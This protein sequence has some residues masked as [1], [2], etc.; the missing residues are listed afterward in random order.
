MSEPRS[1]VLDTNVFVAAAFARTSASARVIERVRSGALTLVWDD[2][3][4]EETE[5]IVRKIPPIAKSPVLEV[6]DAAGRF[7]GPTDPQAFGAIVDPDDR[8]FAALAR[9]AGAILV[10]ADD[11]LLADRAAGDVRILTPSELLEALDA[12]S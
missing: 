6:F 4:R 9:A 7:T 5:H 3:T 8:K 11:H 1:V 2:A 12:A 10:T